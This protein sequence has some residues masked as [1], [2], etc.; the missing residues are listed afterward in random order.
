[1]E[2][3]AR[4]KEFRLQSKSPGTQDLAATPTEFHVT[5]VPSRPFLV[6][7]E[8]SS[9]RRDYI[10]IG[11]L[12]PPTIPSNLVKVILDADLWHFGILTSRMHMAW[13]R[14]IGG[15]LKSDPRY[16][17]G[18][19]YNNFP[20][21]KVEDAQR[22]KIKALA[23]TVLD[24]RDKFPGATFADL[25]D[26]DVMQPELVRAHRALDR[27]VDRLYR[28]TEFVSDRE[29]VEHLF[30]LYEAFVRPPL[31]PATPPSRV[32]KPRSSRRRTE[33]KR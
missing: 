6:I 31:V 1:M 32:R 11:W 21:P 27:A 16:S 22:A 15:R 28:P 4:V 26:A 17:A 10:P 23:Q 3:I 33:P 29:R 14:H 25:Y 30:Q 8:A 2:R 18:I 13:L 12:Q 9:E 5:V 7:P 24:A 20:W 19:V